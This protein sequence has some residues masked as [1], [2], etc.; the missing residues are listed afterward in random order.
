MIEQQQFF[1][2]AAQDELRKSEERFRKI[3]DHSN[4]AIFVIDPER[5]RLLDVNSKACDLLGYSRDEILSLPKA[6]LQGGETAEFSA[7]CR[8]VFENGRGWTDKLTF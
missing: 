3:F 6:A 1:I 5:D 2:Y 4:D 7:F 8:S